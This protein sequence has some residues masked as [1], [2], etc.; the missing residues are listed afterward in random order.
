MKKAMIIMNPTSGKEEAL[1]Y[2][3]NVEEI[4]TD[5]RYEVTVKETAK[6]RDAT[7][8]CI[9]A[10]EHRYDLVVSIGGDGTLHETING[11][12]NQDH[13]PML[14]V[15]PLGTVNDF[16]RALQIP[17]NPEKAIQ[18]L[19][20]TRVKIADLGRLN[21]QLFVNTVAVGS[22]AESLSSVSS[23]DKSRF[24]S[25]AYLKEGIKE[26]IQQPTHP[27]CIRYDGETWEG[28]SPL[29]LA[30]LTNS[31]G[32]F[33]KL[34]PDAAVDDGL[35]HCFII[36][37]LNIFNTITASLSL[38]FGNF[39]NHKDVVYFT[40]KNVRVSSSESVKTNVDGEEGPSLPIQLS[41]IPR[42][43]QVIVPEDASV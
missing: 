15:V 2:V 26:L 18:T 5:Q 14:G 10:C 27:L 32:G 8:F 20:S 36:K 37:D 22:F 31:A 35:L 7:Q 6:E 23:D 24:G 12:I 43:I 16:A 4:L 38:L 28:E 11:L 21:D 25:L 42:H 17:L 34:A 30:A 33:E 19:S 1:N 3:G 29:F 39:K 41:S 40:A 13:L 9:T